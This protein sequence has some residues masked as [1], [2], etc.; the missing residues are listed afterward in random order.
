MKGKL[1]TEG[2]LRLATSSKEILE[3]LIPYPRALMNEGYGKKSVGPQPMMERMKIG[4]GNRNK[5]RCGPNNM[6]LDQW[7][8]DITKNKDLV[9]L[10]GPEIQTRSFDPVSVSSTTGRSLEAQPRGTKGAR[11]IGSTS[12]FV[13]TMKDKKSKGCKI[14]MMEFDDSKS[15]EMVN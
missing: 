7:P 3:G 2:P 8:N 15:I 11:A 5:P 14:E 6:Q 1:P 13:S 12:K 9:G 4:L 10:I